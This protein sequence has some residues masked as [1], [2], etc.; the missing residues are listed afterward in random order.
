MLVRKHS[1]VQYCAVQ[2]ISVC[3]CHS[4]ITAAATARISSTIAT[5][6]SHNCQRRRYHQTSRHP[7]PA[8]A[9]L[10]IATNAEVP[11]CPA[12]NSYH[13]FINLSAHSNKL[14]CLLY[15]M[16]SLPLVVVS[17]SSSAICTENYRTLLLPSSLSCLARWDSQLVRFLTCLLPGI[18]QHRIIIVLS[19]PQHL[20]HRV[21]AGDDDGN[22]NDNNAHDFVARSAITASEHFFSR[23]PSNAVVC[24]KQRLFWELRL[25]LRLVI[26]FPVSGS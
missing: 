8:W 2:Y 21:A 17:S 4:A 3:S 15:T 20:H 14:V 11:F 12:V 1:A 25:P 24:R 13:P 9:S 5:K 23:Q 18:I 22:D 7:S 16:R 10:A 19:A 26:E 6:S